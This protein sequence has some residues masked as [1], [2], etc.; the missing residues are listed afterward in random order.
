[1][2]YLAASTNSVAEY[3][4]HIEIPLQGSDGSNEATAGPLTCARASYSH[5]GLESQ[6]ESTARY[7][8][9]YPRT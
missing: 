3:L 5:M 1:M 7:M 4:T 2:D 6:L 9:S 8:D